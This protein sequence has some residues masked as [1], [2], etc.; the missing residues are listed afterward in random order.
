MQSFWEHTHCCAP[1]HDAQRLVTF[2]DLRIDFQCWCV[3]EKSSLCWTSCAWWV[4]HRGISCGR[5][6][7]VRR[8]IRLKRSAVKPTPVIG[9]CFKWSRLMR[10]M[11]IRL[12]SFNIFFSKAKYD[13]RWSIS[14]WPTLVVTVGVVD[15]SVLVDIWFGLSSSS[16]YVRMNVCLL[17]LF[18]G[19]KDLFCSSSH[20]QYSHVLR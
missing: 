14:Y 10:C 5:I 20:R 4:G 1:E 6:H 17:F 7:I 11:Y 18:Y 15:T 8:M 2:V 9:F 3:C 16:L 19:Q 12:C 13:L